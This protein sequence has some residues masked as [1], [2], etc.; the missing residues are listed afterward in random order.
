MDI[1]NQNTQNKLTNTTSAKMIENHKDAAA[2]LE[3]ATKYHLD[4][5]KHYEEGNLQKAVEYHSKASACTDKAISET[6]TKR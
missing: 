3:S 5:A 1:R 2:H 6:G 4:A